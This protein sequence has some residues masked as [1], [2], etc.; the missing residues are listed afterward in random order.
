MV[1]NQNR[2]DRYPINVVD[3]VN[4]V[5]AVDGDQ[6]YPGRYLMAELEVNWVVVADGGKPL[7]L[8]LSRVE[9]RKRLLFRK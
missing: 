8:I 4:L 6:D 9:K 1:R 5:V 3:D 2:L 7:S